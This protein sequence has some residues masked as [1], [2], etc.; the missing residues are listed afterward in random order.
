MVIKPDLHP[1]HAHHSVPTHHESHLMPAHHE[2]LVHKQVIAPYLPAHHTEPAHT[3]PHR[4]VHP[5]MAVP[6]ADHG[7]HWAAHHVEPH[8]EPMH[9]STEHAHHSPAHVHIDEHSANDESII[10]HQPLLAGLVHGIPVDH[11]TLIT[12]HKEEDLH[13]DPVYDH[14]GLYVDHEITISSQPWHTYGMPVYDEQEVEEQYD[15][16]FLYR[17]PVLPAHDSHPVYFDG[18]HGDMHSFEAP[19]QHH[20]YEQVHPAH[21]ESSEHAAHIYDH[22][23]TS[24]YAT[25]HPDLYDAYHVIDD[26]PFHAHSAPHAIHDTEFHEEVYDEE[27]GVDSHDIFRDHHGH[28]KHHVYDEYMAHSIAHDAPIHH[29]QYGHH[30]HHEDAH[31]TVVVDEDHQHDVHLPITVEHASY[32][33]EH[34]EEAHSRAPYE[35]FRGFVS[36]QYDGIKEFHDGHDIHFSD[37]HHM[38]PFLHDG[39]D[40]GIHEYEDHHWGSH[41]HSSHHMPYDAHEAEHGLHH[42]DHDAHLADVLVHSPHSDFYQPHGHN[43]DYE[44][45]EHQ[46][47]MTPHEYEAKRTEME[48][49]YLAERQRLAEEHHEHHEVAEGD[50]GDLLH[51]LA[52]GAY[53]HYGH[54]VHYGEDDEHHYDHGEHHTTLAEV[55]DLIDHVAHDLGHE[56]G[57]ENPKQDVDHQ[58]VWGG[59]HTEKDLHHAPHHSPIIQEYPRLTGPTQHDH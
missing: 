45:Y 49:H 39:R 47:G 35:A 43:H 1:L 41:G 51:G 42:Q 52:A 22:P 19:Y 40:H 2:A 20:V 44:L 58:I 59:H 33:P 50:V 9:E 29:H 53:H 18:H 4:V 5:H 48:Q 27:H 57:D 7:H 12:H 11:D 56:F 30:G 3:V 34:T 6:H 17:H 10:V 23:L 38:A 13:Q 37:P 31:T 36:K 32:K 26:D 8:H 55:D 25:P 21:E 24:P 54:Q 28:P 15:S 14:T 46:Y 16:E